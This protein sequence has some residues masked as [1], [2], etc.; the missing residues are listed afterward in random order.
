[1]SENGPREGT[2]DL[3]R[4]GP[5]AGRRAVEE[6]SPAGV[7]YGTLSRSLRRRRAELVDLVEAGGTTSSVAEAYQAEHPL[8]PVVT[9]DEVDAAVAEA[10]AKAA[11]KSMGIENERPSR[12]RKPAIRG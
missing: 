11:H 4:P 9:T 8:E 2:R 5:D 7:A 6:D 10:K 3:P 1:V 12:V